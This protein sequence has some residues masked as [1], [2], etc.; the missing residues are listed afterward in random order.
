MKE[1]EFYKGLTFILG[2]ILS[3]LEE[4]RYSFRKKTGRGRKKSGLQKE[5][6]NLFDYE[7]LNISVKKKLSSHKIEAGILESVS[8]IIKEEAKKKN[9]ILEDIQ[10]TV[11]IYQGQATLGKI[12]TVLLHEGRKP[13][14]YFKQQ[15]PMLSTWLVIYKGQKNWEDQLF[16]DLLD[17]MKNF[18]DQSILLS[19]LFKKLD[20]LAKQ[21]KGEKYNFSLNKAIKKSFQ[22]FE[23]DLK[24]KSISILLIV[25]TLK[26]L[27]GKRI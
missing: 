1:N 6:S 9:E 3:E 5:L 15:S 12:I 8:L 4:R 21:N 26:Y 13:V 24:S 18:K 11:A 16:Y 22:I 7:D 10:K 25:K 17:R 27:D 19:S 20:P 14:N 23:F 2:F